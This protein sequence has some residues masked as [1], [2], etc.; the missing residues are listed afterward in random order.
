MKS[1][2]KLRNQLSK[3]LLF[4]LSHSLPL[5]KKPK[6]KEK[7]TRPLV[8]STVNSPHRLIK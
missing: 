1:P 3:F 6:K 8:A 2:N 5:S 4:F 7:K